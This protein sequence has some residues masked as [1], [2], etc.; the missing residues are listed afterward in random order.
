MIDFHETCKQIYIS[1]R[2]NI[3]VVFAIRG[4]VYFFKLTDKRYGAMLKDFPNSL[5][6][7]YDSR[8]TLKWIQ[9]DIL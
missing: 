2:D 6:G 1:T 9:E 8:C 7:I 5:V 3:I 4:D